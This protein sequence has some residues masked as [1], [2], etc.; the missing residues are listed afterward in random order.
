MHVHLVS[1]P[2]CNDMLVEISEIRATPFAF[3]ATDESISLEFRYNIWFWQ[4]K[5]E[6]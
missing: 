3:N 5:V 1:F 6:K 4:T 2:R